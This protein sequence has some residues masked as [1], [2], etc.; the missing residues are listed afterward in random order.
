M[1]RLFHNKLTRYAAIDEEKG[2]R[3]AFDED[4]ASETANAGVLAS[5]AKINDAASAAISLELAA[6]EQ[7]SKPKFGE[8]KVLVTTST[9]ITLTTTRTN[10]R[11]GTKTTQIAC[12]EKPFTSIVVGVPSSKCDPTKTSTTSKSSSTIKTGNPKE[13]V[14]THTTTSVMTLPCGSKGFTQ[15]HHGSGPVVTVEIGT[16]DPKCKASTKTTSTHKSE[17]SHASTTTTHK[18]ITTRITTTESKPVTTEIT[19]TITQT[20]TIGCH[21]ESSRETHHGKHTKTVLIKQVSKLVVRTTS[22]YLLAVRRIRF[23]L[24]ECASYPF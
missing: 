6:A 16:T 15:V 20:E 14:N 3:G 21:E 22:L 1:F 19:K 7:T 4:P 2:V 18:T 9:Y 8:D 12:T 5:V 11:G 10:L 17:T 13:H 23:C 24:L